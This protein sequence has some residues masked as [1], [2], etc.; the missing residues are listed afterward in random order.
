MISANRAI[1]LNEG[2]ETLALARST[3]SAVSPTSKVSRR[4]SAKEV[5]GKILPP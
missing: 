2:A 3:D 4:I 5:P 1:L